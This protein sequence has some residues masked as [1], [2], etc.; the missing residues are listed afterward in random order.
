MP[1][2][3]YVPDGVRCQGSDDTTSYMVT[4]ACIIDDK[5]DGVYMQDIYFGGIAD[6][7]AEAEGI[8]RACVNSTKSGT[9]V[10]KIV[11]LHSGD[12]VLNVMHNVIKRFRDL[13]QQMF[14]T[15]SIMNR[16]TNHKK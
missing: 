4:Y 2:S 7:Y 11:P 3:A 12:V 16:N 13:E 5:E 15:E 8:A 6:G 14:A 10:P 9:I 1:S